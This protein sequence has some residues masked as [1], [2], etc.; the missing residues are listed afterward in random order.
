MRQLSSGQYDVEEIIIKNSI[1]LDTSGGHLQ[2]IQIYDG[3]GGPY[4]FLSGSSDSAAYLTIA[5]A[6]DL[7]VLDHLTL[8]AAPLRHAGGI[9]VVRD[10]LVVGVEDNDLRTRSKILIYSILDLLEGE[11]TPLVT[12]DREGE[13]ERSTAGCTALA[14]IKD[15]WILV[16]GDWDSRHLDFYH[17]ETPMEEGS[18]RL[19]QTLVMNNV[20][21]TDWCDPEWMAYQ[22]INLFEKDDELFLAGLMSDKTRNNVID[23]YLLEDLLEG[24]SL[25][26]KL[27]KI[28]PNTGGD[29]SWGAGIFIRGYQVEILSCARNLDRQLKVYWYGR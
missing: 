28:L 15:G 17:S 25:T 23:I 22:N 24:I 6:N 14:E 18:F 29:F 9:Q 4:F 3:Q 27:R 1:P 13:F 7:E 16:V 5:N 8:F 10:Y 20:D 21:R 2:G 12:I 11:V 19:I 26:K